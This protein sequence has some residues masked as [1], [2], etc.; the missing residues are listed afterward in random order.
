MYLVEVKLGAFKIRR[1]VLN[2]EYLAKVLTENPDYEYVK[3]L[4]EIKDE[5][6]EKPKV[7][8]RRIDY[9]RRKH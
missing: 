9:E 6:I 4:K 5:V 2:S 8:Q 7:K 1:Y 3:V